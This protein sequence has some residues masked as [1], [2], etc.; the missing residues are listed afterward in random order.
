LFV[1]RFV[2]E[3]LIDIARSPNTGSNR[4]TIS[5]VE[6]PRPRLPIRLSHKAGARGE[7]RIHAAD[8]SPN[9]AGQPEYAKACCERNLKRLETDVIDLYYIHR[10]D[11][12][13]PIE[14]TV[15]AMSELVRKGKVRQ[16][17]AYARPAR[18]RAHI[19]SH[20]GITT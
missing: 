8:G 7:D 14:D 16:T 12:A 18:R 17:S 15:G 3:G 10:V 20:L 11:P 1:L 6:A 2:A 13:V 4:A 5:I 19:A 9:S